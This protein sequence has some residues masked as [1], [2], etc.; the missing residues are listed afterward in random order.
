MHIEVEQDD[1]G[2]AYL[3]NIRR[4]LEDVAGQLTRHFVPPPGGRIRVRRR[5][6]GAAPFTP[7]RQS[8]N[9]D[10]IIELTPR[11]QFWC[12]YAYE[13][14]HEFCHILSDYERLL[15]VP[16]QWFHEALCEL[17]SVFTLKQMA[18]T[19]QA[20]PPYPNWRDFAA[21]M[22][23]Y[24][25]DLITRDFLRLPVGVNAGD[26]LQINEPILRANPRQRHL[27]G[28]VVVKLL[29]LFQ[30]APEHW[31]S[32]RHMPNTDES[33][34]E[35]LSQWRGACPDEHKPFVSRIE[36][37]FAKVFRLADPTAFR[38]HG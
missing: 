24:A 34:A 21:S 27:N 33:F 26:W 32:V 2:D 38:H 10:Y 22:N 1:W 9:D 14:A 13:F 30:E 18:D 11:G 15:L 6:N 4:L 37:L 25:D 16:N 12:P 17:A 7:Y 35:F 31:Q 5:P 28:L 8:P 3:D 29:P 23:E 19:W 36:Q 20:D